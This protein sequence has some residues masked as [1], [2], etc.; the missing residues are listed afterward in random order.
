MIINI[1]ISGQVQGVG[2]RAY[3]NRTA[4][5]NGIRGEVW[6]REDG[7]VECIAQHTD[8]LVL[9]SFL[10]ALR[11]GP[12]TVDDVHIFA[13]PKVDYTEFRITSR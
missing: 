10:E 6:N 8:P 4:I 3:V 1:V 11:D 5:L 2:F 7:A 12:G 9:K 13:A